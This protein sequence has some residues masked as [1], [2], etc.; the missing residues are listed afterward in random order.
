MIQ[1]VEALSAGSSGNAVAFQFRVI[2][3]YHHASR[4]VAITPEYRGP[5]PNKG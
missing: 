2:T 3:Q 4:L 1:P 5:A